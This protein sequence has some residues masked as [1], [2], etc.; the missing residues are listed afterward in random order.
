M[1]TTTKGTC[2][3][4]FRLMGVGSDGLVV[5]HGWRESGGRRVG[6]YGRVYHSGSCFGVGRL[7]F[8]VSPKCTEDFV[9]EV[10][11]PMGVH[12]RARVVH[13]G[14][15]P[16]LVY[17][18]KT[19]AANFSDMRGHM[20]LTDRKSGEE[21]WDGYFRWCV[22]ITPGTERQTI[23]CHNEDFG[24]PVP[25]YKQLHKERLDMAKRSEDDIRNDALHCLSRIAQWKPVALVTQE[26]KPKVVHRRRDG[27][28]TMMCQGVFISSEWTGASTLVNSEV[29]CARCLKNMPG[30]PKKD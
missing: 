6:E 13:L 15:M 27:G 2:G 25:S 7:P 17:E 3:A 20:R 1:K 12:A 8:E 29:T 28:Y 23:K 11:Y 24:V 19:F 26:K 22:K 30:I 14:T 4:C 16:D 18:D 5:R 9:E 10:L 21:A